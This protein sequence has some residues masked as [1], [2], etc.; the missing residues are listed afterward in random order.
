[1]LGGKPLSAGREHQ[2]L[3]K[4][5][6]ACRKSGSNFKR[7]AKVKEE[8]EKVEKRSSKREEAEM[9]YVLMP[10][11]C[12]QLNLDKEQAQLPRGEATKHQTRVADGKSG[13]KSDRNRSIRKTN[14]G[15][16]SA[17]HETSG[18]AKA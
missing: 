1:M 12:E 7:C 8:K 3:V 11:E 2:T 5:N 13:R 9:V 18:Q 10:T 14:R 6:A 15:P 16:G 4:I 17:K